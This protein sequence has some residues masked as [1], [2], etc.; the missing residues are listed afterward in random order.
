MYSNMLILDTIKTADLLYHL[1]PP[2]LSIQITNQT[3]Y[4]SLKVSNTRGNISTRS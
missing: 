1:K 3:K 2:T 4:I